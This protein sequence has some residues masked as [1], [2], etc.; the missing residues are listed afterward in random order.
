MT[1]NNTSAL[2]TEDWTSGTAPSFSLTGA[3]VIETITEY[4]Q[5]SK[6]PTHRSP[7]PGTS[8]RTLCERKP[9]LRL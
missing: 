4:F 6:R 9:V 2:T 1:T 8:H 5:A 7:H 3:Y